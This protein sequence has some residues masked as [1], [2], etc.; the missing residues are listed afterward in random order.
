MYVNDLIKEK[1]LFYTGYP[2]SLETC[3]IG[4]NIAENAGG[5]KA[6]KYGVTGRYI[7]GLEIVTPT[8]EIVML[9]GKLV[10]DVSGYDLKQIFIGSEGTL[11]IV[12]K[13]IIK[14]SP[15]PKAKSNL[16]VLFKDV[17]SA[18]DAVPTI[19]TNGIIPMGIEFMDKLSVEN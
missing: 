8:G 19:M 17:K 15:L 16:L 3:F 5:G 9:G 1:G 13:A 10:K 4:G 14:L 18:I 11:G 7:M 6:V 2:M 12:T